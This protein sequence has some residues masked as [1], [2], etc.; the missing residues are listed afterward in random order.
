[1]GNGARFSTN[2]LQNGLSLLTLRKIKT[3]FMGERQYFLSSIEYLPPQ[4]KKQ[5]KNFSPI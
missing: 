3:F 4:M 2:I 1:M 5:K